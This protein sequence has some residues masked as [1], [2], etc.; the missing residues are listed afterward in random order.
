MRNET[1]G[2]Q[3][4]LHNKGHD[5]GDSA[6]EELMEFDTKLS[7][8]PICKMMFSM[9][10]IIFKT[11]LTTFSTLGSQ[12]LTAAGYILLNLNDEVDAQS[13]LGIALIFNLAFFYGFFLSMV[14]K[15]GIDLSVSFGAKNYDQTKKTLNQGAIASV[16]AFCLLTLPASIFSK[17]ILVLVNI[18]PP[19]AE[20][21]KVIILGLLASNFLEMIG[22]F[23][24]EFCM[25]QGI[26]SIFGHTCLLSAIISV[27]FGYYFVVE[28]GL[29]AIGWVY[30]KTIYEL[31]TL[32]VAL[33]VFFKTHA[34]TR[35]FVP[36]KE[37]VDGFWPFF[38]TSVSFAVG[39]YSEFLGNEI[40]SYFIFL[41]KDEPLIAG[42][43]AVLNISALFYSMGETFA[44]ICRTRMNLLIGK[45]LFQLGKN[46]F[47]VFI[48]SLATFGAAVGC[49][50]FTFRH[51]LTSI[52]AGNSPTTSK[53]FLDLI[54]IYSFCLP[55]EL[56]I[57]SSF[58][59]IKTIGSIGFLLL[60]NLLL[61]VGANFFSCYYL[62]VVLK[63]SPYYILIT[64][65]SL[66]YLENILCL[67]KV[68][69][70]DWTGLKVEDEIEPHTERLVPSGL[71]EQGFHP[72]SKLEHDEVK[73]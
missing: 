26:E 19:Q 30:S 21:C 22:D 37:V 63:R 29:G 50:I 33:A 59:G 14:D 23:T 61:F 32:I 43:S 5:T 7:E 66:F 13:N 44:I 15:L 35:G 34:R 28:L 69:M 17:Q 65:Q 27:C 1:D 45:Q 40:A 67:V 42:F 73:P 2:Y 71:E 9:Y 25:A 48:L 49:V 57:T 52:Y 4:N 16:L 6:V 31:I 62:T 64:V 72:D 20:K 41:S 68:M 60:L 11:L 53:Y 58:M 38:W 70:T 18:E 36:I 8:L 46:F 10:K 47:L 3:E 39:S 12:I 56:T 54:S 55:S 51:Q 24:R